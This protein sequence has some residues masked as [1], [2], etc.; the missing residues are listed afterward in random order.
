[1]GNYVFPPIHLGATHTSRYREHYNSTVASDIMYMTYDHKLARRPRREE[2]EPEPKNPFESNRQPSDDDYRKKKATLPLHAGTVPELERIVLHTMVKEAV[3]SK[4]K[5]LG[6][7]MALRA[8]SGES[9]AGGGRS[10]SSGVQIVKA[11]KGA[12]NWKLRQGMPIAAK[13]ELKGDA[14][15]DFIQS[16]V[17]FVLPRMREYPGVILPS[18]TKQQMNS[19]QISGTLSF[20]MAPT[21]M[22]LFPQIEANLDMYSK[23]YGFHMYFVT[24]QRGKGSEHI[25]RQL[26]S[27]FRVPFAR[28]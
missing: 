6:A 24:N 12:A 16:L 11:R 17:D 25:A 19:N 23:M 14:M 8:I 5:L 15:Y 7:I 18:P 9:V 22:A 20:G 13:V 26:M 27:A 10:G 2:P 21:A 28:K 4:A 1:M 3:Q